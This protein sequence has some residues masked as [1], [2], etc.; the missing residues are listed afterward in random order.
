LAVGSDK[1]PNRKSVPRPETGAV[2]NGARRQSDPYPRIGG[3]GA[4]IK[5]KGWHRQ[6]VGDGY[7][8]LL[9]LRWLQFGL[10]WVG[11][12]LGAISLFALLYWLQPGSVAGAKPHSFADDFFFSVQT[13]G[14]IGYGDLWPKSFYANV[15]VTAEAFVSLALTA[16]GTGLIF[17]RVS[18]PTA[19]VVFSR[20][21]VVTPRNGVPTLMFRAGNTRMNQILEADVSLTLARRGFTQEGVEFRGFTDLKTVRGHSPLFGLTWT[22]MHTIDEASPLYGHT[23]ESLEKDFAELVIVLSGVDDTFAQ[24]IHARHSYL[25]HEIAWGRRLADIILQSEDGGR[26]VDYSRFHDLHQDDDPP[27]VPQIPEPRQGDPE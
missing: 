3:S 25:P 9:T 18:R 13:L 5:I 4:G 7:H 8:W 1:L 27:P 20:H 12:Y 24:R 15:L 17:A 19:R 22:V 16:V 14:T 21:V 26:W 2:D 10:L 23:R 6:R 11:V